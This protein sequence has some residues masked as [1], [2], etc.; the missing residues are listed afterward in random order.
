MVKCS[1][2]N[3][4]YSLVTARTTAHKKLRQRRSTAAAR[5]REQDYGSGEPSRR[6]CRHQTESRQRGSPSASSR[7]RSRSPIS[8]RRPSE[9]QQMSPA[10][11][12]RCFLHS[13]ATLVLG[14]PA[15]RLVQSPPTP[16]PPMTCHTRWGYTNR[17]VPTATV[18][19]SEKELPEAP[20]LCLLRE[21]T[22]GKDTDL[23]MRGTCSSQKKR[24]RR[25]PRPSSSSS[26]TST[27]SESSSQFSRDSSSGRRHRHPKP[28]HRR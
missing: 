23:A 28:E 20:G 4:V 24:Q 14:M 8:T 10:V 25:H 1:H 27:D 7:S 22:H 11:T 18:V 13:P 2:R 26:S 5:Q 16:K 19:W 3:H 17:T 12:H 9:G 6:R 21:Y 15:L